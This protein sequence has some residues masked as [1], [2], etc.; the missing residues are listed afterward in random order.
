MKKTVF[1]AHGMESG[2]WGSKITAM[3]EVAKDLGFEVHSPDYTFS[4]DPF[5]RKQWLEENYSRPEGILVQVGSSLGSLVSALTS[6]YF[7]PD[8]M[9][10]LAPAF[11]LYEANPNPIPHSD[12]VEIVHGWDDEVVPVEN[13][14]IYASQYRTSIHILES[15]HRLASVLPEICALFKL[16]LESVVAKST[17]G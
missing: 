12:F 1:F 10:L 9:F 13:S 3:A 14:L 17:I 15:D 7:H 8:G 6:E 16:H 11:G 2:P 5:E 4:K